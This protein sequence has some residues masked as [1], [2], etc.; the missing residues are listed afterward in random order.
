MALGLHE[1]KSS[2]RA[3]GDAELGTGSPLLTTNIPSRTGRLLSI[4]TRFLEDVRHDVERAAA[5]GSDTPPRLRTVHTRQGHASPE[6]RTLN[7]PVPASAGGASPV[8][9]SEL[10]ARYARADP[11]DALLLATEL[12]YEDAGGTKQPL[13]VAEARDSTGVR[14]FWKQPY[15]VDGGHVE[16]GDPEDDGWQDPAAEEMILD[17]AFAVRAR[18]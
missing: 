16:W 2:G 8:V 3:P 6:F 17:A 5:N 7:I 18:R 10:I 11:P 4:A 1:E 12:I 14:L 9:L 13:L 15:T